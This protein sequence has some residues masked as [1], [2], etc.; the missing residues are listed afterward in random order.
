MT[1]V[2]ELVDSAP[3]FPE[4]LKQCE[5]FMIKNGLIDSE[6]RR[7]ENFIW[8]TDGPWD[9]RDFLTKQLFISQIEKPS[10][11][12]GKV[13][14]VRQAFGTWYTQEV[15]QKYMNGP[16]VGHS[17]SSMPRAAFLINVISVK[18]PSLHT[19]HLG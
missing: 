3:I 5:Q 15:L 7:L 12:S 8:C 1:F 13:L 10:W 2:Q 19:F 18:V 17:L 6:G 4:M 16:K 11:L 9:I 14:D